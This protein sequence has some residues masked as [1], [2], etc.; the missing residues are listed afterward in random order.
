MVS[1]CGWSKGSGSASGEAFRITESWYVTVFLF[2][3]CLT[4]LGTLGCSTRSDGRHLGALL[5]RHQTR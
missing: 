4:R 5:V 2:Y 1:C 3:F